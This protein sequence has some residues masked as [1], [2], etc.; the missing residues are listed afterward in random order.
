[1]DGRTRGTDDLSNTRRDRI[2]ASAAKQIDGCVY[3]SNRIPRWK[4]LFDL[5]CIL[6]SLPCWLIL[7]AVVVLGMQIAAP[8][9]ILFRQERIGLNGRRF[10][11]LKFRSMKVN[12]G[13]S[14]HEN[15]LTHLIQSDA[16]M[17]KLDDL[18][19]P[20]VLP[21]GR[22]IRATGLD[23]LPQIFNVIRGEMSLVGPRPCTPA[24]FQRYEI[25]QRERVNAPPGLTGYWQVNGK[26]KTS[27]SMMIA[28]DL[29]YVRN[30]SPW[31][32]FWIALRT[33]PAIV[34]QVREAR[35]GI[36]SS[37]GTDF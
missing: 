34:T 9:P 18:G 16:P 4:R 14:V 28:M 23:E 20:R 27:F 21:F 37:E 36:R 1:M 3:T 17:T 32:D 8:G 2:S 26:N 30:M 5:T 25:S 12:A 35:T 7:M 33:V 22:I 6:L 10:I 15:H 11:C 24:E 29:Y 19:D 13:T 31:L